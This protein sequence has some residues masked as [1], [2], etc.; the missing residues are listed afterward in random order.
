MV[1]CGL[2]WR[3]VGWQPNNETLKPYVTT[4][5]QLCM[6]VLSED[7]EENALVALR[8][9]F[10]LHKNFRPRLEREVQP[11]L[12]FVK[13]IYTSLAA[14]VQE[15][16]NQPA[17]TAAVQGGVKAEPGAMAPASGVGAA[18]KTTGPVKLL[19]SSGSFKVLTECPLITMLLF[20][21]YPR[22][23]NPNMRALV[24]LMMQALQLQAHVNASTV[25]RVRF[26]EFLACQVKTLSFLTYLLR[27]SFDSM[28]P[29]ESTIADCV[30]RLLRICPDEAVSTRKEI[31]VA[32]RHILATDF[33]K[34]FFPHVDVFLQQSTL[35]GQGRQAH[36]VRVAWLAVPCC[37]FRCVGHVP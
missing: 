33:R 8:I 5:L 21:L 34:A 17:T 18:G 29:Y 15:V 36:E 25:V 26:T 11:F 3:G 6:K 2:V 1:W 10:D 7:N 32:T 22:Y 28:K 19:R 35:I 12:D 4:C 23:F 20:Q 16:L 27:G 24:P 14:T 13:S 30:I 37:M 31:L 9:I